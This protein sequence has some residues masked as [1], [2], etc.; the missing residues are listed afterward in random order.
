[1]KKIK[2][3]VKKIIIIIFLLRAVVWITK[4][5]TSKLE[6]RRPRVDYGVRVSLNLCN[7]HKGTWIFFLNFILL[8]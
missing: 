2:V 4:E 8:A 6:L 3:I 5:K 1:M 7:R